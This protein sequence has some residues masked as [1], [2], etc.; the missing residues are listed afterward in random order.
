MLTR[1]LSLVARCYIWVCKTKES[2][3]Y[4]GRLSDFFKSKCAYQLKSAYQSEIKFP[5]IMEVSIDFGLK[6][7]SLSDFIVVR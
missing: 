1:L 6:Q 5:N 7:I 2:V 4:A 3:P